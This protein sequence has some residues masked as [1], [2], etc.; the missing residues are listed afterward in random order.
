MQRRTFLGS[1]LAAAALSRFRRAGSAPA[2]AAEPRGHWPPAVFQD[3]EA[4]WRTLRRDFTIPPEEAFF[5]T[6]TL[7]SSPR[8]VQ[9]AVIDHLNAVDAT[10][11]HW[12]YRPEHP[13][14]FTGYRPELE[15]RTKLA[16]LVGCDA[17]ELALTQ[18]ATFG[19]NYVANG[20][21]LEPGDEVIM[22]NQEHIGC[23]SPWQL[24]AKRYGI[25]IKKVTVPVPPESPQQLIDL[26]VHATTPQ[27]KVWAIP[28]LTSQ[29]AIRFPVD[30]MCR[31][32]RERG[33]VSVID[34]A[35]VCGHLRLDLHAMGCDYYFSSP[36]KWLLTPKGC[37]WLYIARARLDAT[38]ATIVSGQWDNYHDGAYRF[39]QVGS[40]NLSL[41]KGYEAAIDYHQR[42]G[43]ARIETRILA[44][45]NRLREGLRPIPEVHINSP[46]HPE[47]LTA[48]T[49]W[50]LQGWTAGQLMDEL[51]TRA[52]IRCRAMGDPWG[53]RQGCHIYTLP[54]DV[55]RTIATVRA[56]VR[57]RP[58]ASG[59]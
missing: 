20:L 32:A 33:I 35:Q 21:A 8:V 27:T 59:G 44:L 41:L 28:H 10:I 16:A 45:A 9:Q 43:P 2:P 47:L 14:W 23:E 5:N 17:E 58:P 7:G 37:G 25:Y 51:W 30:A 11:A 34:G 24:R 15:L 53:V 22:T 52:R 49:V 3:D 56:M 46:S 19:A 26:F 1:S 39:M 13:D 31:L 29:L 48:T 57:S 6:C 42:I 54:E 36:H 12:D 40:G 38:W 4:Y 55:D 50:S 18:N